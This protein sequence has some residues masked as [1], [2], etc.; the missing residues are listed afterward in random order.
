MMR[1]RNEMSKTDYKNF[2]SSLQSTLVHMFKT[3]YTRNNGFLCDRCLDPMA[4]MEMYLGPEALERAVHTEG[5]G[6]MIARLQTSVIFLIEPQPECI[7]DDSVRLVSTLDELRTYSTHLKRLYAR[8]NIPYV[9]VPMLDR[10]ERVSF[11]LQYLREKSSSLVE[12]V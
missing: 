1:E 3:H 4:Y 9:T 12:S 6:D 11:I 10:Q 7:S 8:F 5:L 2:D